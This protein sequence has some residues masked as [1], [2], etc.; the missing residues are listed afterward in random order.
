MKLLLTSAGLK[1]DSIAKALLDLV[2]RPASQVKLVFIPTAANIEAGDKGW[3]IDDLCNFKKQGFAQIDIVDIS[4]IPRDVWLPKL[5]SADVL[6][7]GGGW[8]SYLMEWLKKSKLM[9]AF[10]PELLKTRIYVGISAGSIITAPFLPKEL[11]NELYAGDVGG[12]LNF[13]PFRIKP[14][15]NSPS[16][17]RSKKELVAKIAKE[18]PETI[19]LIDDNTAIK[20]VD[21]K[22]EVISEGEWE[23]FN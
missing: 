23:K 4:A 6:V 19:Y 12:G 20:V 16:S 10:L 17:P 14:H 13:V 21:G 1:N 2:G 22:V 11:S 18:T 7:F 5:K 9:P 8:I 3:L 15:Y